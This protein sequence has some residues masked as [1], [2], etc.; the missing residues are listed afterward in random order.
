MSDFNHMLATQPHDDTDI[1]S[2]EEFTHTIRGSFEVDVR[3]TGFQLT[4]EDMELLSEWLESRF[5]LPRASW[6]DNHN[7]KYSKEC[8]QRLTEKGKDGKIFT[9]QWE[10]IDVEMEADDY[11]PT[12]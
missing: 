2:D 5:T 9:E 1:D 8:I 3:T 12:Q 6:V 10:L 4:N 11:E 7:R